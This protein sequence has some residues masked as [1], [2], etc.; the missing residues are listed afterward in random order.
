MRD[1]QILYSYLLLSIVII[2]ALVKPGAWRF[3]NLKVSRCMKL[4]SITEWTQILPWPCIDGQ[5]TD[6]FRD[7][8]KNKHTRHK[9]Y[10]N[11][12]NTNKRYKIQSLSEIPWGC[13]YLFT[14]LGKVGKISQ[15]F[16][17]DWICGTLLLFDT[18][19]L[20]MQSWMNFNLHSNVSR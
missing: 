15:N 11:S 3:N 4:K 19:I 16:F 1:F 20:I 6:Q 7:C 14:A 18:F 12:E 5:V 8:I 2:Y 9:R 10:Y 13:N 17:L